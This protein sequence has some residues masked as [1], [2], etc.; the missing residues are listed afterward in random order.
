MHYYFFGLLAAAATAVV[1]MPTPILSGG[2]TS[3]ATITTNPSRP[4]ENVDDDD[5]RSVMPHLVRRS[6]EDVPTPPQEYPVD[7]EPRQDKVEHKEKT[8]DEDAQLPILLQMLEDQFRKLN[9][10]QRALYHACREGYWLEPVRPPFF[11]FP[12]RA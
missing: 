7:N 4:F 10:H 8:A 1:A 6:L 5:G 11:L 3:P 9:P 2:G 12:W